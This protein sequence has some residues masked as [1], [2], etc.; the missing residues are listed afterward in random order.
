MH[1]NIMDLQKSLGVI[2]NIFKREY[3]KPEPLPISML[4]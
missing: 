2:N 3:T 1:E 4:S